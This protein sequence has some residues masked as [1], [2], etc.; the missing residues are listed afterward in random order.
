MTK[1][2]RLLVPEFWKVSKKR[3]TWAVSPRPGPHKK[4][5]C[6]PL[7]IIV[8][9]IL[10]LA[11]TGKEAK[12]IIKKGE[13]FVDGKPRKDY[14]YPAGLMDVISIP[15]ISKHYRIIPYSKGLKLIE[16]PEKEANLKLLRIRDKKIVKKARIQLNFHDGKNLFVEKDVYKTGDSLLVELPSLKII[17]HLKLEKGSLGLILKGKNAGKLAKVHE[18]VISRTQ[19]P[20]KVVCEAEGNRMEVI[21]DY[22]FVVGKEAPV[23]KVSE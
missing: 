18:V 23:I 6:I 13:I 15:K 8:R 16:I 11:E 3:V 19:E 7:L 4:F 17:E 1:L 21:F 2:K 22:F 9:D 10:G 14:A 20:R 12:S 5:E